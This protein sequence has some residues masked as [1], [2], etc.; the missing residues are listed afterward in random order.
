MLVYSIGVITCIEVTLA[1]RIRQ[2]FPNK[3]VI[4]ENAD[5]R[6]LVGQIK[7]SASS[8]DKVFMPNVNAYTYLVACYGHEGDIEGY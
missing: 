5:M 8:L 7:I 3:V 2:T 4:R 6:V 1:K